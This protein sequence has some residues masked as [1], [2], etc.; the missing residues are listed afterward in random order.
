[1]CRSTITVTAYTD[2]AMTELAAIQ[3]E[4]LISRWKAVYC[5]AVRSP[6]DGIQRGTLSSGGEGN[7]R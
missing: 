5:G 1:M 6:R 7:A 4:I 2:D 3:T